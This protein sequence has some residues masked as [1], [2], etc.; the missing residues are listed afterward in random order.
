MSVTAVQGFEDQAYA[1]IIKIG[2]KATTT[3]VARKGDLEVEVSSGASL[4]QE[5]MLETH[6]FNG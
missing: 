1:N 6:I 2:D 3:L 4:D 5:K